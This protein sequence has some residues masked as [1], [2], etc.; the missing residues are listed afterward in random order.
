MGVGIEEEGGVAWSE[1]EVRVL[2]YHCKQW[3]CISVSVRNGKGDRKGRERE[4]EV[5]SS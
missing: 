4:L 5:H 2:Q 3:Y 1:C